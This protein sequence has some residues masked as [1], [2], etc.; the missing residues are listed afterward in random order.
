MATLPVELTSYILTLV[1]SDC[2]HQVCFPRSPKDDLDW[3]LNALS[4]LSCVSHD[5]RDITAD[6]C[7][8]IYGPS[9]K[10]KS[11][12]PSANARLAFLRQSANV[13]SCSLR[14]IIL[15]EEMIKTAFLHAYLMLL[16]SIHMHHAM[17][18]PMPSALFRHMH[19]SVLRSAV[20]IQGISNAAEPKELFA[21]LQTMSRQL[22][23]L[24]HLSLVLLDESDVL[25]ANLD[26]L[27]KF[28]SEAN[29]Y[30]S[31]AIQTIQEVH[32]DISVI[33]KFMHR[34]NETAALA[35]RF[36]GPQ[37][38]PHEL[39]GVV[40]AVSTVRTKIS[41]FKYEAAL[42]DDLIQTLDDLTHDWPAQDLLLT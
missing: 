20:T 38:K 31:G 8:T 3:E 19:P 27:D 16:F 2:V 18:E 35:S 4:N 25:N 12:I 29:I 39:P 9:Y 5:F 40:K 37:V 17:K 34:Y 42:K 22:L 30:S 32:A 11:L 24:I 23:E 7:Q 15:D 10:G 1:I 33:Q 28:D 26:A 14:P 13:D 6:I 41:P 21:N 36:T